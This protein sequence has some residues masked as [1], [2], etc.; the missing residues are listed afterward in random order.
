MDVRPGRHETGPSTTF[1]PIPL[2]I[3]AFYEKPQAFYLLF[4]FRIFRRG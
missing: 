3:T 2:T 1:N 4:S